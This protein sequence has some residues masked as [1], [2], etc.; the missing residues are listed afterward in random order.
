MNPAFPSAF[1]AKVTPA[2]NGCWIWTGSC[3]PR[4]YGQ[5][6]HDGGTRSAHRL[7]YTWAVG[8]IPTD[9]TLDHTCRTRNCVRPDHLEPVTAQ[10]NCRRSH[11]ARGHNV[12]AVV[13][14]TPAVLPGR[15]AGPVVHGR[16][17]TYTNQRCRCEQCRQA[18]ADWRREYRARQQERAA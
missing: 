11:A 18:K 16:V 15:P 8:P 1:A 10:E 9:L 5:F 14:E 2:D 4:G 12:R 13:D 17:S 7:A 6:A 3:S